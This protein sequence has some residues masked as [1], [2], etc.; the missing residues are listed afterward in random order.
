MRDSHTVSEVGSNEI[1]SF[2]ILILLL[3]VCVCKEFT[4]ER[5]PAERDTHL[6]STVTAQVLKIEAIEWAP[7]GDQV[8]MGLEVFGCL[9]QPG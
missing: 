3:C 1:I 9:A 5:T 2:M 7:S 4:R 6:P 8:C